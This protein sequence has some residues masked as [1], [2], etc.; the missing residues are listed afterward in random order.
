[1]RLSLLAL[2]PSALC[3]CGNVPQFADG[4]VPDAPPGDVPDA[5]LPDA[6]PASALSLNFPSKDFGEFTVGQTTN[7]FVARV[8][9]TGATTVGPLDV[10]VAGDTADF[11]VEAECD[12]IEIGGGADCSISVTFQPQAAGARTAEV[13]VF[14]QDDRASSATLSV[15]GTGLVP[16]ALQIDASRYNFEQVQLGTTATHAFVVTNGGD[17]PITGIAPT[18]AGGDA[19]DLTTDC[20]ASL[21]GRATCTVTVSL[22]PT[23]VGAHDA[24][25][26]VE[27]STSPLTASLA[28][29]G[30]ARLTLTTS[31]DGAA[32]GGVSIGGVACA[33][34]CTRSVSEPTVRIAAAVNP[35]ASARFAGWSSPC[36]TAAECEVTVDRAAIAIDA[37]F[38]ELLGLTVT[39]GPGGSVTG[40]DIACPTRCTRTRTRDESVQLV[41]A[42]ATGFRFGAWTGCSSTSG[43][44]CTVTGDVSA[45]SASFVRQFTIEV[46]RSGSG[47]VVEEP[48]GRETIDVEA[49]RTRRVVDSGTRITL[50]AVPVR[51]ESELAGW[52]GACS[53]FGTSTTC[54]LTI[55]ADTT[56]GANFTRIGG[57]ATLSI[58]LTGLPGSGSI[59]VTGQSPCSTADHVVC[60]YAFDAG[61]RVTLTPQFDSRCASFAWT[62]GACTG[63]SACTLGIDGNVDV[64]AVITW[65]TRCPPPGISE[66]SPTVR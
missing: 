38:R 9:N 57:G 13:V 43:T 10:E 39:V 40:P 56:T 20:G 65:G 55:N 32:L 49:G 30:I 15:R 42:P 51:G 28:G 59:D 47:N 36:S 54:E 62:A 18:I 1:M 5:A 37:S 35:G 27:S 7:A 63:T 45:V 12:G 44:T 16:G 6:A 61:T 17:T 24:T 8:R 11:T 41:A 64:T 3:A 23:Q 52:T 4:A 58:D 25:L 46:G 33:L 48:A 21:A 31:G 53:R 66:V 22:A 26:R 34:P 14:D 19:F 50:V 60:T 2:L 29:T